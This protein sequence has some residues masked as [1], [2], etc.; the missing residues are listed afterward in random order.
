MSTVTEQQDETSTAE[1]ALLGSRPAYD[2]LDVVDC[3]SASTI[4]SNSDSRMRPS[5]LR[6]SPA[7]GIGTSMRNRVPGPRRS[8]RRARSARCAASR[9]GDPEGCRPTCRSSPS[10]VASSTIRS[11]ASDGTS[12][13]SIRPIV[14][15]DTPTRRPSSRWLRPAETRAMRTCTPRRR[16]RSLARR[17][18]RCWICFPRSHAADREDRPCTGTFQLITADKI[19]YYSRAVRRLDHRTLGDTCQAPTTGRPAQRS[20]G[21]TT[22]PADPLAAQES[23]VAGPSATP[24]PVGWSTGRTIPTAHE[25]VPAS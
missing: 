13:R 25:F 8:R 21:R 12:A 23:R 5:A 22:R 16:S 4:A 6:R 1:V 11:R 15:C 24:S 20:T 18:P 17:R 7:V 2:R 9:A 19:G 14:W 3:V 10:I